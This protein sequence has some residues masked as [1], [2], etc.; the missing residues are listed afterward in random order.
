MITA[1]QAAILEY[2]SACPEYT[3]RLSV[4]SDR[5]GPEAVLRVQYMLAAGMLWERSGYGHQLRLTAKGLNELDA[6][7]SSAED[8]RRQHAEEER[9]NQIKQELEEKRFRREARRSWVQW[10]ITTIL[11]ILSFCAGAVV[12]K[13]TGFV[14][15]IIT[16]FH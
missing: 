7:R 6:Y 2:L 5:F 13:F 9:N 11:S 16:L 15:W 10:T 4:L 12:E 14:Q 1:D 3:E 8:R